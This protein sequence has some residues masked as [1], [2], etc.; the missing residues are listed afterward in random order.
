ME[1]IDAPTNL[2]FGPGANLGLRFP[3]AAPTRAT[4]CS[5][6]PPRRAGGRGHDR[7]VLAAAAAV[8]TAG[9]CCGDV[10]DS[11]VP[12][13]DPYFGGMVVPGGDRP[14]WEPVDYPAP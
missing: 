11:M 12:V 14:G 3:W 9:L 2:G 8:P 4:G 5:W 10:G 13:I 1:I 6:P 7:D